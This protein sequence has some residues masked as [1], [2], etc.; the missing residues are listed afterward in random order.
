VHGGGAPAV[1]LLAATRAEVGGKSKSQSGEGK[2]HPCPAPP[3]PPPPL[4]SP[5]SFPNI[6]T[7]TRPQNLRA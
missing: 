4:P 2:L 6:R 1:G 3:R 7:P 5:A